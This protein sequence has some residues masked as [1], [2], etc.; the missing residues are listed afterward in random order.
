MSQSDENATSLSPERR[1]LARPRWLAVAAGL[2]GVVALA[3]LIWIWQPWTL[4]PPSPPPDAAG[5]PPVDA[6]PL[7]GELIVRVWSDE[8][9]KKSGL[10]VDVPHSGALPVRNGEKIHFEVHLNQPAHGYILWMDSQGKAW[11]IFPWNLGDSLKVE[12]LTPPRRLPAMQMIQS[13]TV[14]TRGWEMKGPSG[15]ESILL[16]ARK[17]PLPVDVDLREVLGRSPL[18]VAPLDNPNEVVVRGLDGDQAVAEVDL[19]RRPSAKQA[20]ID[21]PLLRLLQRCEP[22]FEMIR[23]VRFAHQEK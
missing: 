10:R 9:P 20:E 14:F 18:P 16:L 8:E 1:S 7:S 6:E 2:A 21:D 3:A 23:A 13:P 12:E 22:H 17:T 19:F 5:Q 15:L 11:P 4:L